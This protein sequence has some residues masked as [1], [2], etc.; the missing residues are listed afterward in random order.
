MNE[1]GN[2]SASLAGRAIAHLALNDTAAALTDAREAVAL[3]EQVSRAGKY[4]EQEVQQRVHQVE[5]ACQGSRKRLF[6]SAQWFPF[7]VQATKCFRN[8][9]PPPEPVALPSSLWTTEM[10]ILP[11]SRRLPAAS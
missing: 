8:A 6:S 3:M 1:P 5:R 10:W 2:L 11:L 4:A 7:P 9:Y